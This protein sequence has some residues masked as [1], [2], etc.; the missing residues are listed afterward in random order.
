MIRYVLNRAIS[1][2]GVMVIVS[3]LVFALIRLIPGDPITI[4][5]GDNLSEEAVETW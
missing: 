5:L 1:A 3:V 4:L 2:A